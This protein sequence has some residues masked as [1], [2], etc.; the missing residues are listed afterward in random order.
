LPLRYRTIHQTFYTHHI[1]TDSKKLVGAFHNFANI[2]TK[3]KDWSSISW[4]NLYLLSLNYF[5]CNLKKLSFLQDP[6]W[7]DL[8]QVSFKVTKYVLWPL[9]IQKI[10]IHCC[11]HNN[12]P[13]VPIPS[14]MNPVSSCTSCLKLCIYPHTSFPSYLLFLEFLTKILHVSLFSLLFATCPA[15][16]VFD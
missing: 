12:P 13:V 2:P 10:L 5:I 8:T 7:L 1:Y 6:T 15:Y 16:P 3:G 4:C 14:Q 9:L 11:V